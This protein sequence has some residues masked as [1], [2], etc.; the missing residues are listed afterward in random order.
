M[1]QYNKLIFECSSAAEATVFRLLMPHLSPLSLIRSE[2]AELPE[3]MR[4]M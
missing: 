3:V 1:R 4:W 2:H